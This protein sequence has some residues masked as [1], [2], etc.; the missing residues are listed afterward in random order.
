M[1]HAAFKALTEIVSAPMRAILLKSAGLAL[2]IIA[3]LG[4]ILHRI[5]LVL[6]E[7]VATWAEQTSGFTFH[8]VWTSIAWILSIISGLGI[9]TGALF[10]MPAVTAFMGSFFADEIAVFVENKYYPTEAPGRSAPFRYAFFEGVKSALLALAV[11]FC[12]L[13]F[14]LF[15]G[16]GVALLFIASA[17]LLGREYFELAA[18][19]FHE[20]AEAKVLRKMNS[21]YVFMAGIVI[22]AFVAIPFVNLATPVFATVFM[23]HIYKQRTRRH[24]SI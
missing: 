19:R 15:G 21:T 3:V 13:P 10:L 7:N 6:L 9:I 24:V 18:M 1:L 8:I 12:L 11:Y 14:F 2:V 22:A 4:I 16:L 20:P 5:I 17:Y 23:T